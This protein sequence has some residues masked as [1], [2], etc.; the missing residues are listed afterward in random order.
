MVVFFSFSLKK[1]VFVKSIQHMPN[2][3]RLIPPLRGN[4][5]K[6]YAGMHHDTVLVN[7]PH[8]QGTL[9]TGRIF[10]FLVLRPPEACRGL[11]GH[12]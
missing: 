3:Q 4:M 8:S 11:Q 2:P 10:L 6:K 12:S 1:L 5:D 7:P 9:V